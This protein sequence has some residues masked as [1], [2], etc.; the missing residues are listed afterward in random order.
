M[1]RAMLLAGALVLPALP[2]L[3]AAPA[4]A[5]DNVIC[6]NT[7]VGCDQT[8]ASIP[9]AIDAADNN[10]VPDTIKVGPGTYTDGP[11]TLDGSV[12]PVTLEGAGAGQTVLA[13][14]ADPDPQQT[15][16]V[17]GATVRHLSISMTPTQSSNDRG[18]ALYNGASADHVVVDGL[19]STNTQG[20]TM[21]DSG[22]SD[23]EI[24]LDPGADPST[25]G[26][27]SEGDNTIADVRISANTGIAVSSAATDT[28]SRVVIRA[29][30]AGISVDGGTVEVDNALINLGDDS[31]TGLAAANFNPGTTPETI[32]ADHV[33]IVGGG[34]GSTGASAYAATPT[35]K[36][37]AQIVLTNSIISGPVTSLAVQASN[38]GAQGG[39]SSAQILVAYTDYDPAAT[40]VTIGANGVGDVFNGPGNLDVVPGFL[41]PDD[42]YRLASTSP[43]VDAG[44]PAAGGPALDLD[45]TPRVVD[46]D[47]D[48]TAVR[49]MGAYEWHDSTPPDTTL[50]SAPSGAIRDTTP[51]F[52]F[53]SETGAVFECKVDA[54]A[55]APCTS[56]F[57]S[58]ALG[59]GG[60]VFMVRAVDAYSNADAT[61]AQRSFTVD[62]V[63]PTTRLVRKPGKVVSAPKAKF[64]FSANEGAATFQCRVD[65]KKYK[66]CL[67]PTKLKVKPGKHTFYVRAVD[68]AG[69][70]D[71]SPAKYRF[72]KVKTPKG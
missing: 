36:Q 46:G 34:T 17:N 59:Q 11:Y 52:A 53:G 1:R 12:Q 5:V 30:D 23:S 24:L 27:F 69:N 29:G 71:A 9:A 18:M 2:A 70:V 21:I 40:Q 31:G 37:T 44:D 35:A 65:G 60:H 51:T 19:G 45:R 61:P 25:R 58:P 66:P 54:A 56:P 8:V 43:L 64:T 48:L 4:Y 3:V 50:V 67:S 38:D 47:L 41:D 28:I 62:T 13:L 57:T 68:A 26:I 49:D 7:A 10:A 22:L 42:D 16:G 14:P 39:N 72:T 6:V 63:S 32:E 55:Y 33:T 20:V 15:L